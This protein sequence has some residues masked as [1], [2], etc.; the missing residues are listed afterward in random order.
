MIAAQMFCVSQRGAVLDYA[1]FVR[2][3]KHEKLKPCKSTSEL[4]ETPVSF[5]SKLMSTEAV[6]IDV[7]LFL[8]PILLISHR[9][10]G[11]NIVPLS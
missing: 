2:R 8:L 7:V 5:T 4:G 6:L 9:G 3:A 11:I 1:H 10:G